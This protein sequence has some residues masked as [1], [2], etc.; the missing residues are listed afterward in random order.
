MPLQEAR[1]GAAGLVTTVVLGT[2]PPQRYEKRS[3]LPAR[4]PTEVKSATRKIR[5]YTL[6]ARRL[7]TAI[8]DSCSLF[9]LSTTA[10]TS[11]SSIA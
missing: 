4:T 1:R 10:V 2:I 7:K 3:R 6:T 11:A 5:D 8:Q 9:R